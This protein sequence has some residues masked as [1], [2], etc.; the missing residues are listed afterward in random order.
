MTSYG[1]AKRANA[2]RGDLPALIGSPSQ[3]GLV[4]LDEDHREQPLI[5]GQVIRV[6]TDSFVFRRDGV[7]EEI[8]LAIV[9]KRVH[10]NEV[11]AY[12]EPRRS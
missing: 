2:A 8:P 12:G 10:G 6:G 7:D 11:V 4:L 3:V 5:E 9:S 1:D